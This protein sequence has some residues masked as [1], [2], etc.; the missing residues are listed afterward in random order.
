MLLPFYILKSP[1]SKCWFLPYALRFLSGWRP[2]TICEPFGGSAVL[3][4]TLLDR[5]FAERVVIGEKDVDL[6]GYWEVAL[7]DPQLAT[8]YDAFTHAALALPAEKQHEF[9]I[10]NVVRMEQTDPALSVLLRTRSTYNGILRG[11]YAPSSSRPISRWCPLTLGSSLRAL[12]SSRH[13]IQVVPDALDALRYSDD[14]DTLAIVDPPYSSGKHSPGHHLYRES[15]VDYKALLNFLMDW[16]GAWLLTSE[17]CP[18][19]FEHLNSPL[20][21]RAYIQKSVVPA[22]IG[23]RRGRKVELLVCRKAR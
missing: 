5:G 14:P 10:E 19:M 11:R 13:K 16:Q 17:F 15:N 20:F 2:R 23:S 6:R 3:S 18:E 22:R 9:F 4:L 21:R 8:R 1:G 12:Y 7:S